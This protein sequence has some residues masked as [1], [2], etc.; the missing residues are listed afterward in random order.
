VSTLPLKEI[1]ASLLK[2]F[3]SANVAVEISRE[4]WRQIYEDTPLLK[5]FAPSRIRVTEADISIPVAIE[6]IGNPRK[7]TASLT[8]LQ[9]LRLLPDDVSLQEREKAV[10]DTISQLAKRGKH[11]FKNKNLSRD[12]QNLLKP[13]LPT[14]DFNSM[15]NALEN[16]R[17]DF[18]KTPTTEFVTR[19]VYQTAE[20]EKISPERIIRLNVKITVD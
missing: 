1:I 15:T 8:H 9:L 2:E 19:F 14:I 20:L 16:L 3:E 7:K 12:V 13:R 10:S 5:E 17:N 11:T 18:L 4:H 6:R